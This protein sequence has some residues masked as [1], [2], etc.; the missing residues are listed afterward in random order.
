ML[1]ISTGARTAEDAWE[2]DGERGGNCTG[3][4]RLSSSS[5][6]PV[7]GV[8]AGQDWPQVGDG[9]GKEPDAFGGGAT[10]E[11]GCVEGWEFVM[12]ASDGMAS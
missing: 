8:R 4:A 3:K 10:G 12:G 5:C 1:G 6:S 11:A 2:A 9:N 7:G